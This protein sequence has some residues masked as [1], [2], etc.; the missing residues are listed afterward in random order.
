MF[1]RML[2]PRGLLIF[3]LIGWLVAC[4]ELPRPFHDEANPLAQ[5]EEIIDVVVAS[6][7]GIPAPLARHV[8]AAVA[9]HLGQI[10]IPATTG[11]A[12]GAR[13]RLSGVVTGEAAAPDVAVIHW[14][15][16]DADGNAVGIHAQGIG[17][18]Q[19]A[20]EGGD[21]RLIGQVGAEAAVALARVIADADTGVAPPPAGSLR[22]EAVRGAPGDGNRA[23]AQA[24]R[25]ELAGSGIPVVEVGQPS[26]YRLIGEVDVAAPMAGRQATRIV[27]RV[28]ALD[29]TEAG[30]AVGRAAQEN[31]V[32]AGSL[33]GAWGEAARAIAAAAAPGIADILKRD[34]GG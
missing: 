30:R 1:M 28:I 3:A 14:T 9:Y 29:G 5:P 27:W 18:P 20:W 4:G 12:A 13:Y 11:T 25:R 23:L 34:S 17:G 21:P 16:L 32:A 31:V 26:A 22:I 19:A 10:D 2:C 7:T 24:I 33:D 15:L 8:A 6:P